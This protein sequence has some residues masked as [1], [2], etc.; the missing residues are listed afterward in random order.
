[1]TQLR[2][3]LAALG[4]TQ[5]RAAHLLGVSQPR[6][7]DLMLDRIDRFSVDILIKLLAM[8]GVKVKLTVRLKSRAA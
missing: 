8:A 4:V 2:K 1:M 6:M 7:S 3:R 5:K